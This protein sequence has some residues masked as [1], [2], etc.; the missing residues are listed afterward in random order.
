MEELSVSDI[1]VTAGDG[2]FIT[3]TGTASPEGATVTVVIQ[4]ADGS[5]GKATGT[6]SNGTFTI[7]VPVHAVPPATGT[8]SIS[9]IAPDEFG[10]LQGDSYKNFKI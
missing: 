10:D 6:V 8:A 5:I 2:A 1:D 3:V 4:M 9:I 7:P